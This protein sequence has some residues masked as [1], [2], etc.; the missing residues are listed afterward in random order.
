MILKAFAKLLP[1][2][3]NVFLLKIPLMPNPRKNHEIA[4]RRTA[5]E[6]LNQIRIAFV[7]PESF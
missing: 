5:T 4:R 1:P 7:F 2:D 3:I 6:S